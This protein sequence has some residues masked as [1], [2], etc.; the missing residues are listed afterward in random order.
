MMARYPE[1]YCYKRFAGFLP[2]HWPS[3]N[4]VN[5]RACKNGETERMT[6]TLEYVASP[7]QSTVV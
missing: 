4:P 3:I 1:G 2:P 5:S 6:S 7:L